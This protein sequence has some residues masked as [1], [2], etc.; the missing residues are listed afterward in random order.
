[1]GPLAG[2]GAAIDA[3]MQG[4]PPGVAV[5]PFGRVPC[6]PRRNRRTDKTLRRR[7]LP[8]TW[9]KV[10]GRLF[11]G[12]RPRR[13]LARPGGAAPRQP[14]ALQ[15]RCC[16]SGRTRQG[17]ARRYASRQTS[18]FGLRP[19]PDLPPHPPRN[20]IIDEPTFLAPT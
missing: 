13:P 12:C 2:Y 3:H 18:G 4:G 17:E 14:V 8:A 16:R 9:G 6:L 19:L 1:Y 7:R 11:G 20:T 15:G 10:A 5:W